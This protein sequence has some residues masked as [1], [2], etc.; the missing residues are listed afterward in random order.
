MEVAFGTVGDQI[1]VDI[2]YEYCL[3]KYLNNANGLKMLAAIRI[4][5]DKNNELFCIFENPD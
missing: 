5:N 3:G 4:S 1:H 2:C